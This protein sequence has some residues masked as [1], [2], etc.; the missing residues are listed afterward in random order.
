MQALRLHSAL[1]IPIED[2][3]TL[4]ALVL[5]FTVQRATLF[6]QLAQ[7]NELQKLHIVLCE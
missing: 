1:A 3:L 2:N 6:V 4:S 5:R 7:N